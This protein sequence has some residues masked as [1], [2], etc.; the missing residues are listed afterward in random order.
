MAP[1]LGQSHSLAFNIKL[2]LGLIIILTISVVCLLVLEKVTPDVPVLYGIKRVQEKIYLKLK[3]PTAEVDYYNFLLNRRLG[4]LD[5]AAKSKDFDLILSSSLRYSATAGEVTDLI[6]DNGLVDKK[7][8][9]EHKFTSHKEILTGLS[10][11]YPRGGAEEWKF[12]QDSF[13][14]L[15]LNLKRL[16]EL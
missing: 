7:E 6:I 9:I 8:T 10:E 3:P 4:E 11:T 12:I 2:K 1:M 16:S 14:Y 5:Y 13:N 15:N